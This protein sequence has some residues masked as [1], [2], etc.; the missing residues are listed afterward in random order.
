MLLES[1]G[2]YPTFPCSPLCCSRTLVDA[3]LFRVAREGGDIFR[4]Q[5]PRA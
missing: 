5:H 2:R 1:P 3:L 4:A